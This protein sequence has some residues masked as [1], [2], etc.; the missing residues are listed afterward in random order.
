MIFLTLFSI[1]NVEA[2]WST[3]GPNLAQPQVG[4]YCPPG[5]TFDGRNCYLMEVPSGTNPFIYGTAF[6]Y[7]APANK[8]CLAP[9]YY[10]GA[11]CFIREIPAG[12]DPFFLGRKIYVK[13]NNHFLYRSEQCPSG[14]AYDGAN[15][16]F[17]K[18]VSGRQA[19]IK[20]GYFGFKKGWLE[21]CNE[22]D[23]NSFKIN[24]SNCGKIAV[25]KNHHTFIHDNMW[26]SAPTDGGLGNFWVLDKMTDPAKNAKRLCEQHYPPR[27]DWELAWSDEFE[28]QP[29]NKKCYT[30]ND[31]LHCIY[32]TDWTFRHC[33]DAPT[34]WT[35]AGMSR[36]SPLIKNKYAGLRH[37]NKCIW[38]VHNGFNTWESDP[39][40]YPL[41]QRRNNFI[42]DNIKIEDGILKMKTS[43]N[44][45]PAS[46]VFDC[47]RAITPSPAN[48]NRHHTNDCPYSGAKLMTPTIAPWYDSHHPDHTD[49]NKRYVGKAIRAGRIEFRVN[50]EQ[51]GHGM[52]SSVWLYVE[53]KDDDHVGIGELDNLEFIGDHE[54]GPSIFKNGAGAYG[55]AHQ[56]IHNWGIPLIEYPHVSSHKSVPIEIGKWHTYAIE[57]DDDEIRVYIDD[58]LTKRLVEGTPVPRPANLPIP[59]DGNTETMPFKIPGR[60]S[61]KLIIG[62]PA[63][64]A[65]WFPTWYR[66]GGIGALGY[67]R[68]DFKETIMHIDY[69]RYYQK[70]QDTGNGTGTTDP[71]GDGVVLPGGISGGI[72]KP[73][74]KKTTR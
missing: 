34:N 39:D 13:T 59:S 67:P 33:D 49:P 74:A 17:G 69:V 2:Q 65:P 12:Y 23:P 60:Q 3:W 62:N 52:W 22:I 35:K 68:T 40:H 61:Y 44:P 19:V 31:K 36:L 29:D 30:S 18:P 5:F 54:A 41:P 15:C 48:G 27:T 46:G 64:N 50:I 11:N 55:M 8:V 72:N 56:T 58:C 45:P 14:S 6:Y 7:T 28:D 21:K 63:S 43:V 4:Q 51:M 16:N 1:F 20:N 66:A 42:P 9:A 47:G 73:A 10:D 24:L 70:K 71:I 53:S 32:A 25:P 37:L 38:S 57:F 26:Y